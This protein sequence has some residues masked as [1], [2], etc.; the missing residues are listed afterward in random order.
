MVGLDERYFQ[1]LRRYRR[2][3]ETAKTWLKCMAASGDSLL[4]RTVG[5]SS[6][7]SQGV[8]APVA[9]QVAPLKRFSPTLSL[10]FSL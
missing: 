5:T 1:R 6:T 4:R 8:V 2:F 3:T 7:S 9:T 10:S